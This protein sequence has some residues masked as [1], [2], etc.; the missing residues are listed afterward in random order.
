MQAQLYQSCTD[1]CSLISSHCLPLG[2]W[3]IT[4]S[5]F[6]TLLS[7][8]VDL[9]TCLHLPAF[10][11]CS[12]SVCSYIDQGNTQFQQDPEGDGYSCYYGGGVGTCD[13]LPD[14]RF[15]RFCPCYTTGRFPVLQYIFISRTI[16]VITKETNN[17]FIILHLNQLHQQRNQPLCHL[18]NQQVQIIYPSILLL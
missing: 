1:A 17:V 5:D 9:S 14:G 12:N 16:L 2:P 6:N 15:R 13:A 18:L 10:G 11:N 7:S 4:L 8:S 3:P